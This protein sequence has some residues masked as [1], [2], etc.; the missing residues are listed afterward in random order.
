MTITEL[1]SK[2]NTE[3]NSLQFEQILET[4]DRHYNF[5]PTAFTNGQQENASGQNNGSCKVLA[6]A[7]DQ[8]LSVAQ[9]LQCFAQYYR[10]DV[11]G[12]PEQDDHQN[13]RQFMQHGWAGISFEAF[14]LT[15]KSEESL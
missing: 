12:H 3:P 8:S 15:A 1:I 7:Q 2:L 9:T 5:Y 13:I 10:D 4:I 14:P 11:L 6:F